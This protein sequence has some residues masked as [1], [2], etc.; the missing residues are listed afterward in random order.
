M[1][2]LIGAFGFKGIKSSL[3]SNYAFDVGVAA[4]KTCEWSVEGQFME[5]KC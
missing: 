3:K 1:F 4:E 5:I 2:S